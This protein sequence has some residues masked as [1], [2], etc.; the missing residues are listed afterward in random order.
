MDGGFFEK[1]QALQ[2]SGSLSKEEFDAM[3]QDYLDK[4]GG[5]KKRNKKRRQ[6]EMVSSV[7]FN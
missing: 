3:L 4:A 5:S 6:E 1:I 7:V 2:A